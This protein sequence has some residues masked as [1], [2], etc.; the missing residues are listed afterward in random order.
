MPAMPKGLRMSPL[1]ATQLIAEF[2]P[3][4]VRTV[5]ILRAAGLPPTQFRLAGK[6][7]VMTDG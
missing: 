7:T 6:S 5:V 2:N 4:S 1:L 3:S